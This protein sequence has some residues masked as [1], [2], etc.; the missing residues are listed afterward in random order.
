MI[1][2]IIQIKCRG[3]FVGTYMGYNGNKATLD[4]NNILTI[5]LAFIKWQKKMAMYISKYDK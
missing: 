3:N 2:M 1:P 4:F 5:T